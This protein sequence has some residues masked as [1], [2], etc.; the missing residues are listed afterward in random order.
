MSFSIVLIPQRTGYLQYPSLEVRMTRPQ[1]S[2][3]RFAD[4]KTAAKDIIASEL[5]YV[6]QAESILVI[7]NLNSS[8]VS[9]DSSDSGDGAWLVE[10][11]SR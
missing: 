11:R 9:L 2:K 8:T 7:P 4:S 5:D 3:G 1:G 6:N 10:S